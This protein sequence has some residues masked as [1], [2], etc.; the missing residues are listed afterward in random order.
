MAVL[1]SIVSH[2]KTVLVLGSANGAFDRAFESAS[3]W[4]I[5]R[6][7]MN[8]KYAS[9]AHTRTLDILDWLDWI[10]SI[11]E[12]TLVIASPNCHQY[13][14]ARSPDQVLEPDLRVPEAIRAIIQHLEPKWWIVENV[15]G[16]KEWFK[17][18][19][20]TVTQSL[21]PFYF[22]GRF[23]HL[24]VTVDRRQSPFDESHL[25]NNSPLRAG[26]WLFNGVPYAKWLTD[27]NAEMPL[28]ISKALL[29]AIDTH[30]SLED[31][32]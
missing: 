31:F 11:G 6:I 13:S 24:A 8:P 4:D 28:E 2:R 19:F 9:V 26:R 25:P 30:V 27:Q 5:V 1:G 22:W 23:P 12:I 14:T 3:N 16:A 20:G 15:K 21:G 32:Q 7:D 29:E 17:P 18:I 10:E